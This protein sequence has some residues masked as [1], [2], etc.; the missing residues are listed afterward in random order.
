MYII[1]R[2]FWTIFASTPCLSKLDDENGCK[3]GE[4]MGGIALPSFLPLWKN[5]TQIFQEAQEGLY[6]I[7]WFNNL[8]NMQGG[9]PD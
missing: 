3:G 6:F 9:I 5:V 4:Y 2:S 7:V 1:L 8:K